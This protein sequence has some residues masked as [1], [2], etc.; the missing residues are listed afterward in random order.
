[1]KENKL[2]VKVNESEFAVDVID[3]IYHINGKQYD[4]NLIKQFPKDVQALSINN[5]IFTLGIENRSDGEKKI[6]LENF[7]YN[8]TVKTEQFAKFEKYMQVK[9]GGSSKGG[10]V[11]APM[12]GL[13]VKIN[14]Q[15]GDEVKK[16]DKL[17]SLEAMKME[18]AI[19]SSTAG[20]IKQILVKEGQIV[21]K[22]A[23][24]LEIE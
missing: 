3:G 23:V 22:D 5:K 18:N 10:K 17:I 9:S 7:D 6:R 14:V 16:G 8:V 11:K 20:V 15:I 21:E 13:V 2:I 12:P 19:S 24:L 4:V 1:M